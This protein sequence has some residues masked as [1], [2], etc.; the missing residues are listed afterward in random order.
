MATRRL[1]PPERLGGIEIESLFKTDKAERLVNA[2]V[3]LLIGYALLDQ[4]VGDIV[5]HGERIEERAFLEDHSGA[6]AQ[7]E[8]L[9]F[10]HVRRCLRR[11][12]DAAL[13]EGEAAQ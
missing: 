11:K 5:A 3:D 12:A 2:A 8:E 4:L 9:L 10:G 6:S 13:S 1:M 7:G